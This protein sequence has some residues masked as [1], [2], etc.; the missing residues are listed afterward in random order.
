MWDV[1]PT[2]ANMFG[3]DYTYALGNDI[4]SD[5]EKIVVFPNGNVL[6]NKLYYS[7][8]NDEYIPFTEEPI[9]ASY[10]TNL[11]DYADTRLEVSKAIIV[12]NLIDLEEKNLK[13]WKDEKGN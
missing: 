10:I 6:T 7:N 3:L 4:F 13:G 5:N 11:K 1:L 2:V 8:L 9:D 12:H